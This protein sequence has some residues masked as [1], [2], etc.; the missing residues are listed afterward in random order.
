MKRMTAALTITACALAFA[1]ARAEA[2][3][4]SLQFRAPLN[5]LFPV[6]PRSHAFNYGRHRH[7]AGH[8][9]RRHRAA[10]FPGL[11]GPAVVYQNGE[12]GIPPE[13]NETAAMPLPVAQPVIHRIGETGGCGLQQLDVPGHRGRTTVNVWRC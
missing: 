8:H 10:L 3:T 12:I 4:T 11:R 6:T 13:A 7:H 1:P 9:H 2:Q 5:Y